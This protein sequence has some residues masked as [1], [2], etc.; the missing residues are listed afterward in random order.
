MARSTAPVCR[1]CC[2]WHPLGLRGARAGA[3]PLHCSQHRSRKSLSGGR[4]LA[5]VFRHVTKDRGERPQV[6]PMANPVGSRRLA[7][8]LAVAGTPRFTRRA[9]RGDPSA[10]AFDVHFKDRR[11]VHEAIDSRERHG[12]IR[13]DTRPFAKW[14]ISRDDQ[15]A[16]FVTSGDQLK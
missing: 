14:M 13:K 8:A 1:S 9:G 5:P 3:T 15:A 4:K 10:I 7:I 6:L 12:G 16:S 11:M 2:R